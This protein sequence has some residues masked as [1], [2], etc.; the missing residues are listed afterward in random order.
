MV[1]AVGDA[2]SEARYED[3]GLRGFVNL[4]DEVSVGSQ[5]AGRRSMGFAMV[6]TV[7]RACSR[8][9]RPNL[10]LQ[11]LVCEAFEALDGVPQ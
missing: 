10:N 2:S 11:E 8:A 9:K 5:S 7:E 4:G 6:V 3:Q 1:T